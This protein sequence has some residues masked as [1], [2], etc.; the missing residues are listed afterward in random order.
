MANSVSGT[1]TGTGSPGPVGSRPVA[2]V[3]RPVSRW[4]LIAVLAAM[5]SAVAGAIVQHAV[6]QHKAEV[7]LYRNQVG[8]TVT[9]FLAEEDRQLAQPAAQRS[10]PYFSD[11]ADSISQ[12][13]GV[14]DSGNLTVSV[15][16]GSTSPAH[17]IAYAVSVSSPHGSSTIVVW[18]IRVGGTA[19]QG[20]CVLSSSLLGPGRATAD[21][22]LGGDMFV[23]ACQPRWWAPGP[24]D[25]S[26]PRLSLTPI[27]RPAR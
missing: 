18:D 1:R 3:P 21:L 27:P 2:G 5:A 17:Q 23:E 7:T 4:W 25:G 11:L 16:A 12:D 22:D 24:V 15:V 19:N 8:T 9:R 6:D 14:S 13:P 20:T 10:D 26:Q